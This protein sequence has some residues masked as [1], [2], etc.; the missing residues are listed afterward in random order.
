MSRP[1]SSHV[2]QLTLTPA[3]VA[4][5]SRRRPGVRR[6]ASGRPKSTGFSRARRPRPVPGGEAAR[7]SP[8]PREHPKS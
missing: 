3:R 4:T 5:S 2:Y 7:L 8:H 1:C 6:L